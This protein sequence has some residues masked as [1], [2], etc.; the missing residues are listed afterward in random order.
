MVYSFLFDFA[1]EMFQLTSDL[2]GP[3]EE[4][5]KMTNHLLYLSNIFRQVGLT[6]QCKLKLACSPRS[7]L[8][9]DYTDCEI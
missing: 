2:D 5:F 6:L 9:R 8:T 7:S 4:K 1:D 3:R